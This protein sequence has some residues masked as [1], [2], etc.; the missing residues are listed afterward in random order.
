ME[1]AKSNWLQMVNLQL[2]PPYVIT[3]PG[4]FELG[5]YFGINNFQKCAG[6]RIADSV[7]LAAAGSDQNNNVLMTSTQLKKICIS[8]WDSNRKTLAVENLPLT[9]LCIDGSSEIHAGPFYE[10]DFPI[11]WSK[12]SLTIVDGIP[13]PASGFYLLSIQVYLI[14]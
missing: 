8:L 3:K 4:T 10:L 11:D 7:Q 13:N 9:A 1:T 12:S 2:S 5:Q 6:L 14:P